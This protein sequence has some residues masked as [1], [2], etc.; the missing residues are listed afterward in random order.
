MPALCAAGFLLLAAAPPAA[1]AGE[2][3]LEVEEGVCDRLVAHIPDDDVTYQ[4]GVDVHGNPVVPADI[5][6]PIVTPEVFV[7]PLEV[8]LQDR[9]G[10]PADPT[11]FEGDIAIGIV[12]IE[13][14]RVTYNGQ[15][16]TDPQAAAL[17]EL[18]RRR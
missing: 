9:F 15:E 5:D 6:P 8:D 12:R 16:L 11:F 3:Y 18:C 4:P 13:G 2:P 14:D 17:A 10:I 7:I 1:A